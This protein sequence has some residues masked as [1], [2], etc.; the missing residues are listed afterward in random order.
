[1]AAHG[2]LPLINQSHS[3]SSTNGRREKNPCKQ[4][5]P[6]KHRAYLRMSVN[7]SKIGR[8]NR[9]KLPK[10]ISAKCIWQQ[11]PA[12]LE[13]FTS[14]VNDEMQMLFTP[15]QCKP[16]PGMNRTCFH[17]LKADKQSIIRSTKSPNAHWLSNHS[18]RLS[19]ALLPAGRL[20]VSCQELTPPTGAAPLS[21][22]SKMGI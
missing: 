1:M 3:S 10:I 15:L 14:T 18:E 8:K 20:D 12:H 21:H 19:C 5:A 13:A 22:Q 11:K 2:P 6:V 7:T 4:T 17:P 16:V 9:L